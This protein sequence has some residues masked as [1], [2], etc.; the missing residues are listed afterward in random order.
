MCKT[1]SESDNWHF[2]NIIEKICSSVLHFFSLKIKD[3]RKIMQT[4]VFIFFS[5]IQRKIF[6]V[7][8]NKDFS[9]K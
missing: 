9:D 5:C 1:S 7:Y 4:L 2:T 8:K 3:V 6:F